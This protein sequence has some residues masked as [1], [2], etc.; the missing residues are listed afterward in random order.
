[1]AKTYQ[2]KKKEQPI[3]DSLIANGHTNVQTQVDAL[4]VGSLG[5]W[6]LRNGNI[7][8][9]RRPSLLYCQEDMLFPTHIFWDM[10]TKLVQENTKQ[11]IAS[12]SSL[13]D[14]R[15]IPE[16]NI[17]L[18]HGSRH[19]SPKIDYVISLLLSEWSA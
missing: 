5:S 12:S 4:I 6:I 7:I 15:I 17:E 8:R 3:V 2:K 14:V 1:M 16:G 11:H 19:R 9:I 18:C 10:Y 13:F